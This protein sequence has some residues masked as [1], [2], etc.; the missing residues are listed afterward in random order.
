MFNQAFVISCK[1]PKSIRNDILPIA[2][3][4]WQVLSEYAFIILHQPFAG[5]L[6]YQLLNHLEEVYPKN[7]KEHNVNLDFRL[8]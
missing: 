3:L 7:L 8:Y 5:M 2:Y 1:Y 6:L 4:L